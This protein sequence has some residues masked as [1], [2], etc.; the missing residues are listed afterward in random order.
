MGNPTRVSCPRLP[1]T[2]LNIA[3]SPIPGFLTNPATGIEPAFRMEELFRARAISSTFKVLS[4][5][6]NRKK[7]RLSPAFL[8]RLPMIGCMQIPSIMKMSPSV[9]YCR[10]ILK[11]KCIYILF[12]IS[13]SPAVQEHARRNFHWLR[14]KSGDCGHCIFNHIWFIGRQN[15]QPLLQGFQLF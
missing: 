5:S 8:P 13:P 15:L 2:I 10:P 11:K 6:M 14:S 7:I 12:V 1:A 4:C 3:P 9:F